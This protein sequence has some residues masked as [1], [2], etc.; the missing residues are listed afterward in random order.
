M[1]V[2]GIV[3]S[4]REGGNTEILVAEALKVCK[5]E[6]RMKRDEKGGTY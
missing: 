6:L 5:K 2:I 3:G 4:P 1:K